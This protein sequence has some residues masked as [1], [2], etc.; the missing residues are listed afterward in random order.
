MVCVLFVVN[1][2]KLSLS[3]HHLF[4][5]SHTV[6]TPFHYVFQRPGSGKR[7]AKIKEKCGLSV[8]TADY[9]VLTILGF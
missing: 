1:N 5:S 7:E 8:K 2:C 9:K 4:Q 3:A 6:A